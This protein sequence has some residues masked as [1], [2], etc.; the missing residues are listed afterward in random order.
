M[1]V[2]NIN[3]LHYLLLLY[4]LLV[5][6]IIYLLHITE[7]CTVI[8]VGS[9]GNLSRSQSLYRALGLI[10]SVPFANFQ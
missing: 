10:F 1:H 5:I 6:V 4:L 9:G 8:Y 3:Y 7:Q 2:I